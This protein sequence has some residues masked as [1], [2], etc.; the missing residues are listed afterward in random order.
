MKFLGT[1]LIKKSL[2][3]LRKRP[4]YAWQIELTTKCP[5]KCRM[6]IREGLEL[7]NDRTMDIEDFRK[8]VPYF[9]K[10]KHIILEGWGESLL[11]K[12][13]IEAIQLVKTTGAH[14][15]FVTSGFGLH[16]AKV[17]E[18]I[19]AGI[20]FVGFSLAGT[21]AATH[22]AIRQNSHFGPLMEAIR[23]ITKIKAQRKL[24]RP[25]LHLVYLML[26]DNIS[27]VP[28][29]PEFAAQYGVHQVFLINLI[30]VT[31]EW[32]DQQKVFT[33]GQDNKYE[34]LVQ[35]AKEN[36]RKFGVSLRCPSL[37][38]QEVPLCAENPLTN[39]YISVDGEVSPCVHLNPPTSS[40]FRRI[41]CGT[42]RYVE[43]VSFGNIFKQPFPA[44]WES[45]TYVDFRD[46]F[47]RRRKTYREK[48]GDPWDVDSIKKT[49]DLPLPD[50]PQACAS[51]HEMLGV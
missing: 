50:P 18:L 8:L 1:E 27:D 14:V 24:K 7:W 5:L 42:E 16:Y 38:P 22:E 48:Y 19:E 26:K 34:K 46:C 30:N 6:C 25:R 13:L 40:P 45:K 2:L 35:E 39:L 20:D 31:T 33:C 12:D 51:C 32:Q 49:A 17:I 10:I 41:F 29:L 23:T 3:R 21:T 11:Y 47:A 36:A 28:G 44:I 9:R 15:G 4:F 37:S 43:K